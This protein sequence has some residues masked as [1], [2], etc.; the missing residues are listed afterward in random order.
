MDAIETKYQVSEHI[1]IDRT[2]HLSNTFIN[3]ML[4]H[5]RYINTLRID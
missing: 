4:K 3:K 1:K 5:E 2:S